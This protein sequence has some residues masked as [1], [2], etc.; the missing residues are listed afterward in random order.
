MPDKELN[1]V[2][3]DEGSIAST[4]FIIFEEK[5]L[6]FIFSLSRCLL[7]LVFEREV[8]VKDGESDSRYC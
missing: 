7:L 2:D 1:P 3:I 5:R 6:V 4:L 8:A